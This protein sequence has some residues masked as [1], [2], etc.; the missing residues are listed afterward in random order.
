MSGPMPASV[1][2]SPRRAAFS[3]GLGP[4]TDARGAGRAMRPRRQE[5]GSVTEGGPDAVEVLVD[6]AD[7]DALDDLLRGH[8]GHA[9]EHGAALVELL[10]RERPHGGRGRRGVLLVEREGVRLGAVG[11][12]RRM[13]GVPVVERRYC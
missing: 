13:L 2:T 11:V 1:G 9:G 5:S 7:Q 4:A 10:V 6:V 8:R 3:G 12:L